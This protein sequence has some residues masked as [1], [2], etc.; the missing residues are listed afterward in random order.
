MKNQSL[1]T[2]VEISTTVKVYCD[3]CDNVIEIG[4]ACLPTP[5]DI[6]NNLWRLK[7]TTVSDDNGKIL[8]I[9]PNC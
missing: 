7:W 1:G 2:F 8:H 5:S 9:C 6:I 3:V 4:W